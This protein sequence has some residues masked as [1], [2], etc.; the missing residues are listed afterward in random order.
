MESF[1]S[2]RARVVRRYFQLKA[3]K[4]FTESSLRGSKS[5]IATTIAIAIPIH[6][7]QPVGS[8][9]K[10][11]RG[12]SSEA[13]GLAR[14]QAKLSRAFSEVKAKNVATLKGTDKKSNQAFC[15]FPLVVGKRVKAKGMEEGSEG[16]VKGGMGG[17]E[18]ERKIR[19]SSDDAT[20][21]TTKRR[22]RQKRCN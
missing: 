12:Y 7:Q 3:S 14:S 1:S 5:P 8:S 9:G 4:D 11:G 19:D 6:A 18:A 13:N 2:R 20:S 16:N 17:S 22:Q 21:R 10:L 15:A